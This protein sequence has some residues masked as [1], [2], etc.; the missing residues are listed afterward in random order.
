MSYLSVV[1][2]A[3]IVL[4]AAPTFARASDTATDDDGVEE[5]QDLQILNPGN[6]TPEAP[7]PLSVAQIFGR[8]HAALVHL[9]IG[10][11]AA[12]C[13]VEIARLVRKK[14]TLGGCA[15]FLSIAAILSYLP[16]ALSGLLRAH[17]LYASTPAPHIFT[18]HRNLMI[19]AASVLSVST[20]L[21]V[22]KKNELTGTVRVAV[23]VLLAV[24]FALTAVGAHHGGM[25]VYGEQFLPY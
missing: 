4:N 17:E 2:S 9:P 6:Q 5:V 14:T 13:L 24:A 20:M 23:L 22:A 10:I 12:L 8:N 16:A 3:L 15:L 19:A 18:E 1:F 21:R 25:L 7:A 11:L